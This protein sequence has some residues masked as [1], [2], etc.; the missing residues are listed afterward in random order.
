LPFS[1]RG[2]IDALGM[3]RQDK[4]VLRF[5]APFW[6]TRATRWDIVGTDTDFPLWLNL[7]PLTGEPVLV[8]LFGGESADRL[9][10]ATDSEVLEAALASLE[11]FMDPELVQDDNT[12]QDD[13]EQ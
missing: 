8:A 10:S 12:D 2:A 1:H 11:P 9:S 7:E 5:E 4:L 13:T 6:S 3:G